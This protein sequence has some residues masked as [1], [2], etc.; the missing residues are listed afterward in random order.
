MSKA[1]SLNRL[2]NLDLAFGFL[3]PTLGIGF[4]LGLI[5]CGVGEEFRGASG[6]LFLCYYNP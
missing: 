6:G 5:W 3:P 2:G 4:I 1:F